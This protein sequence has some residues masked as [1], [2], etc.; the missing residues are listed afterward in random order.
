MDFRFLF[1]FFKSG[2]TWRYI[3]VCYEIHFLYIICKTLMMINHHHGLFL[4]CFLSVLLRGSR[5]YVN[6]WIL[7]P[8]SF[9]AIV[10][11]ASADL[12]AA[13]LHHNVCCTETLTN[14]ATQ[15]EIFKRKS[16]IWYEITFQNTGF[17]FRLVTFGLKSITQYSL[18]C[19]I[20]IG[21]FRFTKLN[22]FDFEKELNVLMPNI[23]INLSFELTKVDYLNWPSKVQ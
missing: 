8:R 13:A 12:L 22:V 5:C 11:V 7:L 9:V 15:L 6:F 18:H 16:L 20:R 19:N 4:F 23:K 1:I 10:Q 14:K 21:L 3:N 2:I 17:H